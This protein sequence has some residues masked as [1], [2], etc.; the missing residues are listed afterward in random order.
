[1]RERHGTAGHNHQYREYSFDICEME[2]T[3]LRRLHPQLANAQIS[4]QHHQA[5]KHYRKQIVCDWREAQADVLEAL[6][7]SHQRDHKAHQKHIER[8]IT[9]GA[10]KGV[11][12]GKD[13]FLHAHEQQERKRARH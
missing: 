7:K 11:F 6:E 2:F 3:V 9:F 10:L 5:A 13:Q 4:D 8:H 12:A 1:M